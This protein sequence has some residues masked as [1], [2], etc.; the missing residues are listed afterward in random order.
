MVYKDIK[1]LKLKKPNA[2]KLIG[3]MRVRGGDRT[4]NK[5]EASFSSWSDCEV[6]GLMFGLRQEML[7]VSRSTR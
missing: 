1:N 5:R 4:S 3:V 6:T 7:A 2:I